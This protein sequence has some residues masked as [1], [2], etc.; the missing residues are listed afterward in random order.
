MGYF[1][2]F[3]IGLLVG[4]HLVKEDKKISQ[5]ENVNIYKKYDREI[6]K[7][8]NSKEVKAN[9]I[10]ICSTASGLSNNK[11]YLLTDETDILV[12]KQ[13]MDL[14]DNCIKL[15]KKLEIINKYQKLNNESSKK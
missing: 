9:Y 1:G 3:C 6:A 5:N 10:S 13:R 8:K 4:G 2:T 14:Y 15:Y 7:L 12:T 11:S